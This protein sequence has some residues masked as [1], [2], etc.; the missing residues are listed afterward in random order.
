MS[1]MSIVIDQSIVGWILV[2][3]TTKASSPPPPGSPI[4]SG[5][6]QCVLGLGRSDSSGGMAS[7]AGLTTYTKLSGW[8]WCRLHLLAATSIPSFLLQA[9][10]ILRAGGQVLQRCSFLLCSAASSAL[11]SGHQ[12]CLTSS[13]LASPRKA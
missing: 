9:L 10:L 3:Q 6:P 13:Q 1:N 4:A 12:L 7:Q 5:C 11:H 8:H 2:D